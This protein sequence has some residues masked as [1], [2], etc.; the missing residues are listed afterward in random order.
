MS[1]LSLTDKLGTLLDAKPIE[2]PKQ[3]DTR[4]L[5][6]TRGWADCPLCSMSVNDCRCDPDDYSAAVYALRSTPYR[7][8][9]HN[10]C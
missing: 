8:G 10:G 3:I 6:L 1:I 4:P 2:P 5:R 9:E 7:N